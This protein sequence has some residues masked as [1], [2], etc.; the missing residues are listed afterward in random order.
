MSQTRHEARPNREW[1]LKMADIE[2]TCRCVA[3]GGMAADLSLIE[4]VDSLSQIVFGRLIEFARRARGLSVE[5]LANRADVDLD[6]IV[7]IECDEDS[8]PQPRTVYQLAQVLALP[9]G[10][11]TEVAGLAKPR[12]QVSEAALRFA[13]RSEPTTQLSKAEQQAF[14]EFVKVLAEASDGG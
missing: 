4:Q 7:A 2:D 9:A 13:A 1:L 10:S 5:Q 3:V 14:E 8:V 6:E 11:L 12:Q